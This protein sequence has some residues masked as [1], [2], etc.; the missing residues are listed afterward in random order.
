MLTVKVD[1]NND[2]FCD[3]YHARQE[4]ARI[5]RAIA[6][7]IE[8][9]EDTSHNLTVHDYNGNDV[10]RFKLTFGETERVYGK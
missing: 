9:G 6:S 3:E 10:G 5:L 1:T 4:A 7:R 2:A 8:A